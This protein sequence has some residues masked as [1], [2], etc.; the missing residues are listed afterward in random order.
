MS[1]TGMRGFALQCPWSNCFP[2]LYNYYPMQPCS[3]TPFADFREVIDHIWKY[4]SSLLSCDRCDH[5]FFS[6]KRGEKDRPALDRLKHEHIKEHH[7]DKSKEQSRTARDCIRTM[8]DKQDDILRNWKAKNSKDK[9]AVKP[10][11]ISLC[12]SLFGDIE[13]PTNLTYTYWVP[14]YT[15]N[16]DYAGLGK[17]NEEYVMQRRS[18]AHQQLVTDPQ[19]PQDPLS[20]DGQS[21]L[22]NWTVP[23]VAPDQDSGYGSKPP[24]ETSHQVQLNNG[25]YTDVPWGYNCYW[26]QSDGNMDFAM[27][28]IYF[29][30]AIQQVPPF[31]VEPDD[32]SDGPVS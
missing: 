18:D 20:L 27:A 16:P 26:S 12:R 17:R 13:V 31:E 1:D 2:Q 8:T 3:K 19:H 24:G 23:K 4:H 22:G 11:Y 14:Y 10:N 28:G 7:S 29:N 21:L 30:E 5:R 25:T 32:D 15:T 9:D 6:A